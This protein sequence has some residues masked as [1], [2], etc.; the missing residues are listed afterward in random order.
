MGLNLIS[1]LNPSELLSHDWLENAILGVCQKA[2]PSEQALRV[3]SIS[4]KDDGISPHKDYSF[5]LHAGDSDFRIHLRLHFALFSI[6]SGS[7]DIKASKEYA[8]LR[9]VYRQGF[10]APFSYSFSAT[11]QPFGHSYVMMDPGDGERWDKF[12]DSYREVQE[13]II[14]SLATEMNKL[15][16][17]IE[18]KHPLL[19]VIEV[20][21]FLGRLWGRVTRL[22]DMDLKHY[23]SVSLEKIKQIQPLAPVLL[24]GSLDLN[25]IL[26]Q[27]DHISTVIN[28]EHAA[29]GDPRWDVAAA[30]L[31]IQMKNDKM[32]ANRFVTN[33]AQQFGLPVDH[34]D[35]WEGLV[36][37][38]MYTLSR[39]L[40]FMDERS[41]QT[42]LGLRSSLF[43]QE[44]FYKNKLNSVFG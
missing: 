8:V 23:F 2:F 40:R 32:L 31:S 18:P 11:S 4:L 38:R 10:P 16:R 44:D 25:N 6:W 17:S 22:L 27:Q 21:P 39:W 34:L 13:K 1:K 43:E 5:F 24:H 15:H 20:E 9:H 12:T 30:S 19:P 3:D 26:I 37:L 41:Q 36:A 28:W 29:I 33:Y 42:I 7:E 35:V 14:D